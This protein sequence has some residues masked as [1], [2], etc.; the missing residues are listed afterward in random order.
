MSD[1]VIISGSPSAS[2]RLY[3]VLDVA[4]GALREAGLAAAWIHV[5]ELPAEDLL[6]ARFDSPSVEKAVRLVEQADAVI[7]ATPVYKASYTG[8]LKAFL[9]VLPQKGLADKLVLP[10]AIG[11]T[12]AHL[13]MIDYA[14]KPV[15]FALGAQHVL[16][17]VYV[18]DAHVV[19]TERGD[20]ELAEEVAQ[21]LDD[22]LKRFIREIS[23]QRERSFAEEGVS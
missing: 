7:V 18:Q 2:S 14:L 9:D 16:G 15:L 21:R 19:R 6:H 8:I 3:G 17:G 1:V 4:A 12:I 11:G 23:R 20:F 5:R 10:I 22:A 13:L